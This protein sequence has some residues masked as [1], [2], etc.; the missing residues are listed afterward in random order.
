MV[1]LCE[2]KQEKRQDE[3]NNHCIGQF[4]PETGEIISNGKYGRPNGS[5][6]PVQN[7]QVSSQREVVNQTKGISELN[8]RIS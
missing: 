5:A 1:K 3:M 7:E 4:D 8:N 2:W 6:A